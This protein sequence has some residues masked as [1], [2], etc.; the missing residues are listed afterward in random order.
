M[1][2]IVTQTRLKELMDYCPDTGI[3][4]WKIANGRRIHVGDFAGSVVKKG[5]V[6]IGIDGR[7]YR[8][9]R[10]AWLYVYGKWPEKYIDHI[11]GS[12][13]DNRITNLRDVDN[14][15]N[16]ENLQCATLRNKS[17][18]ILGVSKQSPKKRWR[19]Q[20]TIKGKNVHLG[21][22]DT[23]EEASNAYVT[24][25]RQFHVGCTI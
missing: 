2:P 20:I 19:A 11:N 24:A 13:T 16:M 17:S 1:K 14:S 25:K 22:F 21:Y 5:Y 8:A 7:V 12:M 9:H 23:A 15:T 4:T 10:L 6:V 3:F 18:R